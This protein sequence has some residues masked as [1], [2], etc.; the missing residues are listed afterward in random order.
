M[1][2][3]VAHLSEGQPPGRLLRAL[4]MLCVHARGLRCR[5]KHGPWLLL[6]GS[7]RLRAAVCVPGLRCVVTRGGLVCRQASIPLHTKAGRQA[8]VRLA[9]ET[10][11]SG[12]PLNTGPP[13]A[14]ST[15]Y[16]NRQV[17]VMPRHRQHLTALRI[18]KRHA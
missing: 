6:P 15:V 8:A 10:Q 7:L 3:A 9:H 12:R 17:Y 13:A 11:A 4:G 1:R 18:D 2:S 16:M 14:P 5:G